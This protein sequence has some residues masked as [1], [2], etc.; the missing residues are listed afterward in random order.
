M[1]ASHVSVIKE[2]IVE[3]LSVMG[4][5]AQVFERVEEGRVVFNIKTPDAQLLIGKQGQNLEAL[6]HLVY[7]ILRKFPELERVSFALD[8]DDYKEK[9]VIYLKELARRAAHQAR[10]SG[11]GVALPPMAASERKV[12]HNYLSLFSDLNSAS[13]GDEPN[14]R[15]LIKVKNRPAPGQDDEFVFIENT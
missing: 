7:L 6:Q 12:I 14:R 5:V 10:S 11:R 2:K 4:F 1:E 3:L 8:V 9:R 13:T 15:V